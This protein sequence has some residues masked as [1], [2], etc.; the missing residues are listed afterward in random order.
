MNTVSK[1][2]KENAQRIL[3]EH[4]RRYPLMQLEDLYKL[5]HQASFGSEHAV[6]SADEA[7]QWLNDEWARMGD[8]PP[9]PLSDVISPDGQILRIHLRP[10]AANGGSLATLL[11]AFVR[12]ATGYCASPD[13][14]GRY[15]ECAIALAVEGQLPWLADEITHFLARRREEGWPVMPHSKTYREAYRPAYRVIARCYWLPRDETR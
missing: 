11:Q 2:W 12:T 15:A 6:P 9:E 13:V 10:Y 3:R 4:V 1:N 7:L 14:I 5:I 8:G